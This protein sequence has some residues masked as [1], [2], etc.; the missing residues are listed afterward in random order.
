MYAIRSYYAHWEI[1]L[2]S[3]KEVGPTLFY[4]LLVITVSFV[5]VFTLTEQSG[6]LFKPFV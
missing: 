2:A 6:R 5:P 4:S 3:A 1:I